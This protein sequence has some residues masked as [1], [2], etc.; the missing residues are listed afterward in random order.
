M[1][2]SRRMHVVKTAQDLIEEELQVCFLEILSRVD[3][4]VQI[5]QKNRE[6]IEDAVRS[7]VGNDTRWWA[8][9]YKWEE[10]RF[11]RKNC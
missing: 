2:Y 9:K 1:D 10:K 5:L 11:L 3:D 8:V 7:Y 4:V 6:G